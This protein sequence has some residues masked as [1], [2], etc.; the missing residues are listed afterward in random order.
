MSKLGVSEASLKAIK[1]PVA[2]LI[3]D[4]DPVRR[5]YVA[6]LEKVRPDWP[7]IVIT[8]AGHV[9]CIAKAQFQDELK[10]QLA[11]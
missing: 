10:K 8:G 7:V 6:P 5:L 9:N 11:K 2:I 3:G 1:L 4:R